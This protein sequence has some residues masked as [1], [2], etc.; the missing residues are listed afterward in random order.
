MIYCAPWASI[1]S[2]LCCKLNHQE[3]PHNATENARVTQ[4]GSPATATLNFDSYHDDDS[5]SPDKKPTATQEDLA[6]KAN[7]PSYYDL[8]DPKQVVYMKGG[9]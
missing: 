1:I 3:H 8:I 7:M 2:L 5:W 9:C 4:S 6:T